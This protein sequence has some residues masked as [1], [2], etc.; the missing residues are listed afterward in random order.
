MQQQ[1]QILTYIK[2]LLYALHIL[3]LNPHKPLEIQAILSH[4][5]GEETEV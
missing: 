2:H 5:D 4:V 1:S 3:S